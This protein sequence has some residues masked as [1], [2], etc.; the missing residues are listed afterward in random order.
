MELT[1][2]VV[3]RYYRAPEIMLNSQHY[4]NKIDVWSVGC[5]FA[6][7]LT[8]KFLFPGQNYIEQIKLIINAL[9]SQSEEDLSFMT[10][11]SAK[12]FVLQMQNIPKKDIR[13]IIDYDDPDA[14]ELLE[15][16]LVFNPNKR[17]SIQDAINSKYISQI[18]E[19]IVDPVFTGNLN[20]NFDQKRY[21]NFDE[22]Y[23]IFLNEINCFETG[24]I[25]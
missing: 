21:D 10:N 18:K 7:L 19:G 4:S 20:L 13:S 8:K 12:S 23:N 16:M 1:E 17:I 14:L 15:Q 11:S 5:T 6:E 2:Y 22:L 9:G 3:T 24:V 25:M